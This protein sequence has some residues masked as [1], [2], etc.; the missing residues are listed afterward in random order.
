MRSNNF[1]VQ[2]AL[3]FITSDN[4]F[5]KFLCMDK[6]YE[7]T[8]FRNF[9]GNIHFMSGSK[10]V[11]RAKEFLESIHIDALFSQFFARLSALETRDVKII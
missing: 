4:E 1:D 9:F 11:N 5:S 3:P 6:R 8:N 10:K 2:R 7:K